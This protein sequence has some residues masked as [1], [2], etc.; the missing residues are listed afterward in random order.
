MDRS[1]A[2]AWLRQHVGDDSDRELQLSEEI[3]GQ[4]LD[5]SRIADPAGVAPGLPSWVDSWDLN[6]AAAAGWR[7]KASR[8]ATTASPRSLEGD[9]APNDYRYLN[10]VR[11]AEYYDGR[12]QPG[13]LA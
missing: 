1:D 7:I 6:R 5:E 11:Q 3:L 12:R 8:L 4:L 2:L 9:R 10:A 13:R